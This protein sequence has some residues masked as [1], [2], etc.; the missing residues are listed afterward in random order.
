MRKTLY[1]LPALAE[2][3]SACNRRH[4]EHI[5]QWTDHTDERHR[6]GQITATVRE[7]DGRTYRGVNFFRDED[8]SFLQ[9]LLRGEHPISGLRNRALQTHLPGRKPAKIG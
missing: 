7:A 5:S 6:M 2:A 1:S 8:A 4:I 9:A 3:M